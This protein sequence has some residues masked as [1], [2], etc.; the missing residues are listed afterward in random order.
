LV[1]AGFIIGKVIEMVISIPGLYV[2]IKED[3]IV[4]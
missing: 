2:R 1:N 3:G 4:I